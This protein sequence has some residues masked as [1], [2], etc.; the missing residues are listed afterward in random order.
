MSVNRVLMLLL[1]LL[2]AGRAANAGVLHMKNG[3]QITGTIKKIWDGDV[4]IEPSYADEFSVSQEDVAYMESDDSKLFEL[5]LDDGTPLVGSLAGQDDNGNQVLMVDGEAQIIPLA[6]LAE[7]E[8]PEKLFDW[9]ANADLNSAFRSGNTNSRSATITMDLMLKK[10]RHTNF[11]NLIWQ[12]EQQTI[13]GVSNQV[14]DRDRYSY[15]Y[16]YS[17]ADPWFLGGSASWESDPVK[18]L[19]YRYNAVPAAGYNFWDDA[20]RE[21]GIQFGAGYQAEK[22]TDENGMARDGA[23]AV[24][25]FLLRFRYDFGDPDIEVYMN[26]TTTTAFYGRRNTVT[27]FNTGAEYEISDLLYFNLGLFLDYESQP[28]EGASGEDISVLFGFGVEFE[29]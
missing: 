3:D 11:V 10:N 12:N 6:A 14:Q 27:Q 26:N 8:E 16:N 24:A 22:I 13:D 21:L 5:E 4:Y 23:G 29:K 1:G 15:N 17:V 7:L 2:L 9:S 20:Y 18:G 28:T 19:N 25:G